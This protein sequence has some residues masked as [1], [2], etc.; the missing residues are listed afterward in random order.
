MSLQITVIS[1]NNLLSSQ[2]QEI[3]NVCTEAHEQD[4]TPILALFPDATHVLAHLEDKLVSHA[5]WVTRWLQPD[6]LPPLKTAYIEAVATAPAYQG[7]GIGS[8]VMQRVAAEIQNYTLGALSPAHAH[9]GFYKRLGWEIWPG[10]KAI[11]T[12]NTVIETPDENIMIL[13]TT[14]TPLLNIHAAITAEW[15]EGELW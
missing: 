14:Q 10:S 2:R 7:R 5:C 9:I 11:R 15:R 3:I 12:S 13:R 8:Q 4:F 1:I 6:G